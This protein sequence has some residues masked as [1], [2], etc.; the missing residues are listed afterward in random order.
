MTFSRKRNLAKYFVTLLL[1]PTTSAAFL[2]TRPRPKTV[3]VVRSSSSALLTK[4][5][6][7]QAGQ[8]VVVGS[9]N[10]DL[11]SYTSAVP[12][13]GQTVMGKAFGTSCGGKGANQAVAAARLGVVPVSMVCRVADDVFGQS[14]L[15]NFRK[16]VSLAAIYVCYGCV[17]TRVFSFW[18]HRRI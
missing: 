1:P 12:V 14:L 10:Q 2:H 18:S 8:V 16:N 6:A 7:Q 17:L 5:A 15:N 3:L 13:L 11:T 9:A 4:M